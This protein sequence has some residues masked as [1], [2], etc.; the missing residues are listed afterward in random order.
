MTT[1]NNP[2]TSTLNLNSIMLGT[3]QAK[4]LGEFYEKVFGRP[5]DME[6]EG[7]W[8]MWQVGNTSLSIG[9][10]SE[11]LGQAKEPAR[12]ILNFETKLVKEEFDRLK[13]IGATIVKEPY[14]MDGAWIATLADADGNFIQLMTPWEME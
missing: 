4:V 3:S 9:K 11:V 10:H 8:Y 14:E 5:A 1:E 2:H 12:I 6:E 7:G 13:G